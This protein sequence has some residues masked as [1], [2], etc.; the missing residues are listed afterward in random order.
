[1]QSKK[2]PKI[3]SNN[4]RLRH[5]FSELNLK[6]RIKGNLS[7][8]DNWRFHKA[9]AAGPWCS[10][11]NCI[12]AHKRSLKAP[13]GNEWLERIYHYR[14]FFCCFREYKKELRRRKGAEK[15]WFTSPTMAQSFLSEPREKKVLAFTKGTTPSELLTREHQATINQK[16]SRSATMKRDLSFAHRL[17]LPTM[18]ETFPMAWSTYFKLQ[19]CNI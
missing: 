12:L 4:W 14:S 13:N 16:S 1:M 5:F 19:F 18:A 3:F 17:H 9:F 10:V 7:A 15:S 8:A 11:V 2:I 6:H